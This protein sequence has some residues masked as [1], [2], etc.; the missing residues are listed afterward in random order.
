MQSLNEELQ[1]VN[2]ELQARVDELSR[3][4][5]DMKNLLNSTNIATL[6]LDETLRIRRFTTQA[7]Q[8]VKLIPGDVGRPITD[9]ASDLIYPGLYDDVQQV[10][11]TL[12]FKEKSLV[13][14]E[15]FWY[16][17]RIMPYR[18]LDNRIDG[19]VITIMDNADTKKLEISR[20]DNRNDLKNL[21]DAIPVSIILLDVIFNE[22]GQYRSYRFAQGNALWE[23]TMGF[24][25]D[26]VGGKLV[27]EVWPDLDPSWG[28][29]FE[30]VALTGEQGE[31]DLVLTATGRQYHCKVTRPGS[32]RGRLCLIF[33]DSRS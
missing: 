28:K 19:V 1:T 33:E 30:H 3:S 20:L 25:N 2:H 17:I 24:S 18:T 22:D 7:S 9:I 10:L 15:G 12:V 11:Q 26:E 16:T 4:N 14:H 27:E 32:G 21:L 23:Q 31:F 5:N 8:V 6:F 13:T 29:K